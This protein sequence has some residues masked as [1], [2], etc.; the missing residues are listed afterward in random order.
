MRLGLDIGGTKTDA[1][2]VDDDGTIVDRVRLATGFGRRR[3]SAPP[4]T[5]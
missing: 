2:A 5:A 1:V 4:S 3:S